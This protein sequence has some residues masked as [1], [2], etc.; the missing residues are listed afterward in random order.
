VA[1]LSA[2]SL[3]VLAIWFKDNT[4]HL[5]HLS[6]FPRDI[7]GHFFA[8]QVRLSRERIE[9]NTLTRSSFVDELHHKLAMRDSGDRRMQSGTALYPKLITVEELV[10]ESPF[11]KLERGPPWLAL[12]SLPWRV[13]VGQLLNVKIL[14]VQRG[15]IVEVAHFL[16]QNCEA[17]PSDLLPALEEIELRL[18]LR[19]VYSSVTYISDSRREEPLANFNPFVT[20]RQQ[21]GRP[22]RVVWNDDLDLPSHYL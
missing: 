13:F 19:P 22:V 7:E 4:S 3:Q 9:I 12:D 11:S 5:S 21:A 20:A 2:P 15:L 10:L 14:R 16:S 17:S 1:G 6:R 8:A 18:K